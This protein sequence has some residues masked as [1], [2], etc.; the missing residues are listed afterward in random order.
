MRRPNTLYFVTAGAVLVP[1]VLALFF[2]ARTALP[3]ADVL[4]QD[5]ASK[6]IISVADYNPGDV[7]IVLLNGLRVVVWRR[8]EADKL[9]AASQNTPDDWK[10][11]HTKVFGRP[12]AVFADDANLT[13]D[14]EWFFALAE[15]SGSFQVLLPRT[16]DF[17]GFFE[18]KYARHF[19][20]AGRIRKGGET[21][22]TIIEAEYAHDGRS[23]RLYLNI[24]P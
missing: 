19:D 22:L 5:A 21:N 9:L 3:S 11:K 10:Q 6:P 4:A 12:E 16:G 15:F 7:K 23:I 17:D 24:D 2:L 8:D 1:F 18:V 20:L 13:L 14:G